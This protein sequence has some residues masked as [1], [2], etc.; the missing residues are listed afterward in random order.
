MGAGEVLGAREEHLA[1]SF[2]KLCYL[3]SELNVLVRLAD[4]DELDDCV[5]GMFS[6]VDRLVV[7]SPYLNQEFA[8]YILAH[9]LGHVLDLDAMTENEKQEHLQTISNYHL[10]QQL[11]LDLIPGMSLYMAYSEKIAS[12]LGEELLQ[13][14]G[15]V[16][17]R[18]IVRMLRSKCLRG[19]R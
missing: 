6:P 16:L 11:E 3:A 12:Q 13:Q 10:T 9:E 19:I 1:R 7:L 18:R 15:V 2:E 14:L 5:C 17:S 8:C 4:D